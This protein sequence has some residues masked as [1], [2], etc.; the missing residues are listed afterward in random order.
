MQCININVV[1]KTLSGI[2]RFTASPQ[3]PLGKLTALPHAG[4]RRM[5]SLLI[6]FH[7][8]THVVILRFYDITALSIIGYTVWNMVHTAVNFISQTRRI[9]SLLPSFPVPLLFNPLNDF[10]YLLFILQFPPV[11]GKTHFTAQIGRVSC[12]WF[13]ITDPSQS[14]WILSLCAWI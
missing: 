14:G 8:T 3:T 4:S 1:Y 11:W 2:T 6:A 12:S 13:R 10:F 7:Y 9:S 5:C